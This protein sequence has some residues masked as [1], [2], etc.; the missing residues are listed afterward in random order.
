MTEKPKIK[1]K[2][3]YQA[4]TVTIGDTTRAIADVPQ[5]MHA[6]LAL[7]GLRYR[8]VSGR[9]DMW[10]RLIA[11]EPIGRKAAVKKLDDW[12]EAAAVVHALDTVKAAGIK[13]PPGKTIRVTPEFKL[14]LDNAKQATTAWTRE[15]RAAAK[16]IPAIVEEHARITGRDVS[17]GSLFAPASA[18]IEALKLAAD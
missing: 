5:S 9:G 18:P 12:A 6:A 3:D 4:G 7:D 13:A 14:A 2:V 16:T 1:T 15:Q 11:G 10:A 8:L 17:V